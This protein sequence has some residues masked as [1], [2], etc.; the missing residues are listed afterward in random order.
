MVEFTDQPVVTK[1]G[2]P[3]VK[4]DPQVEEWCEA[5]YT[6][7]KA[8]QVP[9]NPDDPDTPGFLRMLR[10]HATRRGKAVDTQFVDI[11]GEPHL[12]FRMRDK[13][14]YNRPPLPREVSSK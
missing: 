7:G 3:R 12:R 4:I 9:L 6:S 8:L 5:T 14:V 11:Q 2:A 10:I 13:K 1:R